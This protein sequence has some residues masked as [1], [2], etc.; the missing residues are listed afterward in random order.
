MIYIG[1]TIGIS[2]S[3]ALLHTI[4]IGTTIG[5][6]I[7]VRQWKCTISPNSFH[8]VFGKKIAELPYPL[9]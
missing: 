6:G 3:G 4:R 1:I 2:P 8:A 7:G 9:W 5:I